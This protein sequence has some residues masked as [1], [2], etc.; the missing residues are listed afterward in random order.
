MFPFAL[1]N[2]FSPKTSSV[3]AKYVFKL[4]NGLYCIKPF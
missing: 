4:E 3:I 2:L 1:L